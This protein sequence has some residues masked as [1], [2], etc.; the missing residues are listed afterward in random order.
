MDDS[1]LLNRRLVNNRCWGS[2]STPRGNG[3]W[4]AAFVRFDRRI[5]N[6][7][8]R[9]L[10]TLNTW[11]RDVCAWQRG[12]DSLTRLR[13][14]AQQSQMRRP[15][16]NSSLQIIKPNKKQ[17]GNLLQK[18]YFNFVFYFY[19]VYSYFLHVQNS[20]DSVATAHISLSLTL[21]NS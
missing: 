19:F 7:Q 16:L 17:T 9:M 2:L 21:N 15:I 10:Q 4:D 3:E 1:R 5:L 20:P 18:L 8:R 13:L 14:S 6:E 12:S 11:V